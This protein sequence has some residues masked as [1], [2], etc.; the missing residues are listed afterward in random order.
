MGDDLIMNQKIS[1]IEALKGFSLN[2]DHIN[3]H[4]ITIKTPKN[5]IIKHNEKM[6]IPSL[7]M[8]HYKD[9]LSNGDLVIIFEVVFP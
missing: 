1:L 2:I 8:H 9:S 6:R 7:G 5:K 4:K 3:D